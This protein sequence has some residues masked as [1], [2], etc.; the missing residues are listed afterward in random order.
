[1]LFFIILIPGVFLEVNDRYDLPLGGCA[2]L[3][4]FWSIQNWSNQGMICRKK[5]PGLINIGRNRRL[6]FKW[7]IRSERTLMARVTV[8][9]LKIN[10]KRWPKPKDSY[11]GFIRLDQHWKRCAGSFALL[12]SIREWGA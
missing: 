2:Y 6:R 11:I 5:C 12:D 4:N 1:M 9:T 7:M 3:D 8:P 10:G